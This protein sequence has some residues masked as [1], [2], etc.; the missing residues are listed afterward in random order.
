[1]TPEQRKKMQ[2]IGKQI[3]DALPDIF[4][5]VSFNLSKV[6]RNVK[7]TYNELMQTEPE[8]KS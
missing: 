4:G 7:I 2:E 5:S 6:S 3:K 1:M 8:Q